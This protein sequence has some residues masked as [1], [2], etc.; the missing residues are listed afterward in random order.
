MSPTVGLSGNFNALQVELRS[1]GP[2]ELTPAYNC[3]RNNRTLRIRLTDPNPPAPPLTYLNLP[4][5]RA[6][7]RD[8]QVVPE[9][10]KFMYRRAMVEI[11]R[12]CFPAKD[13]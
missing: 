5:M 13:G 6:A 11:L 3:R 10:H 12:F 1:A 8:I 2:I 7:V 4:A 9:S